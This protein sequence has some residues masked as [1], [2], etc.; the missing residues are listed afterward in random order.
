MRKLL[1]P[2]TIGLILTGCGGYDAKDL[3]SSDGDRFNPGSRYTERDGGKPASG[4]VTRTENGVKTLEFSVK[5]GRADGKWVAHD[6][7]GNLTQ[8]LELRAGEFTGSSTVYCTSKG[9]EKKPSMTI[10]VKSGERTDTTFDCATGF[11]LRQTVKIDAPG[12]PNHRH[13]VG[14]QKAWQIVEGKQVLRGV[15]RYASDGSGK[16][17]GVSE[18]YFP[19]G[20]IGVRKAYKAGELSGRSEEYY[21]LDD[22]TSRLS[23]VSNYVGGQPAGEQLRYFR[24]PWPEGTVSQRQDVVDG[25]EKTLTTFTSGQ[26]NVYERSLDNSNN[27]QLIQLLQGRQQGYANQVP[28][29]QG[30]E[31]LLTNSKVDVNAPL[32]QEGKAPIHLVAENAY[33]LIVK[34][35]ADASKQSFNGRNRLM[36]CLNNDISCSADHVL[37]LA[38]E[39]AAKQ[40]DL[41]GNTPLHLLCRSAKFM[42]F[43]EGSS[44]DERLLSLAAKQDVNAKDYQGKTALHYCVKKN[45]QFIDA[46][47][48]A[49]A[50]LDAADYAG[51]TPMHALFLVNI[52][53]ETIAGSA[54]QVRWSQAAVEKAGGLM[55]HSKFRFDAPFPGFP[56]GLK[57][58]MIENGDAQAAMAADRVTPKA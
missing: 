35:G 4:S 40:V 24:A 26:A 47:V 3:K 37:R 55:S 46:L 19:S 53:L 42:G 44:A 52:D 2:A 29:L 16:R 27:Y 58:L 32:D 36:H 13:T 33:D 51:I 22:G 31:Y 49:G 34:L 30:L 18:V 1:L 45:P 56:Q 7:Q 8:D 10:V 57:Q 15:E 28:D 43:R 23:E 5:D 48:A 21:Q 41:Y 6:E 14:E 50:D 54:Y 20:A 11:S 9:D 39:P 38:D 17:E 12:T 25:T